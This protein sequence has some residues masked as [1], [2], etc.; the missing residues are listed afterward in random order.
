M[1]YLQSAALATSGIPHNR[2]ENTSKH[3]TQVAEKGIKE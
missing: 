3:K 2:K 1:K